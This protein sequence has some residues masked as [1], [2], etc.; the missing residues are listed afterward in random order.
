MPLVPLSNWHKPCPLNHWTPPPA[1]LTALSFIHPKGEACRPEEVWL[2]CIIRCILLNSL[3]TCCWLSE[4][5]RRIW[6]GERNQENEARTQKAEIIKR[7]TV[8]RIK[9][10]GW[11][12]MWMLRQVQVIHWVGSLVHADQDFLQHHR[13]NPWLLLGVFWITDGDS[14]YWI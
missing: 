7:L 2:I 1:N 3:Q 5:H 6:C 9:K 11:Q 13:E 8:L 14:K 12:D 4:E 10:E